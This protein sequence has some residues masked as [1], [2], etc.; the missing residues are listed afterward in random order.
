MGSL[1]YLMLTSLDGFIED[2]SGSFDWAAPDEEVHG[3]V[4]DLA[5]PVGTHLYGRRM[6]EVMTAWQN[7]GVGPE[8]P[9][10]LV[11]FGTL[12]RAADKVVF[13]STLEEPSTPRT[14]LE[15]R[16]DPEAVRSLKELSD[17]DISIGGPDL[18]ASAFEAGLVD[19]VHLILSPIA[20]GGGKPALPPGVRL[21][22]DLR[23]TRAFANGMI[24]VHYAV[25]G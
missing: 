7:L 8:A 19:T 2:P 10:E 13:S 17:R 23:G 16:F 22:L 6:Y 15:R 14:R 9:P 11:D 25:R 18:A 4:N 21:R 5:R 24:H 20:V 3:Y 1:M 12:W